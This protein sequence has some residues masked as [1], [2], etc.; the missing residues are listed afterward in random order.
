MDRLDSPS[1]EIPDVRRPGQPMVSFPLKLPAEAISK[2]QVKA[3]Q[4]GISKTALVRALVLKELAE[5]E[6]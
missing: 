2:I 6:P 1:I 3:D 5:L 4:M